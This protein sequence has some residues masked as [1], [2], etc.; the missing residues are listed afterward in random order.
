LSTV[1]PSQTWGVQGVH[2]KNLEGQRGWAS[3]DNQRQ[4]L[5]SLAEKLQINS[6]TD[7]YKLKRSDILSN[8]GTGFLKRAGGLVTMLTS[9][10]PS[11]DYILA[12]ALEEILISNI[13]YCTFAM[14]TCRLTLRDILN[15]I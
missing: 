7:W 13:I 14:E 15:I 5:Q 10:Y 9:A 8:G 1:Y 6:P 12:W 4:W 11:E 3:K 2:P